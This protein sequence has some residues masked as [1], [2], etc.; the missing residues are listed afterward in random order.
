MLELHLKRS[1]NAMEDVD[2][3]LRK[4]QIPKGRLVHNVSLGDVHDEIGL[5]CRYVA[6]G[7]FSKQKNQIEQ[8]MCVSKMHNGYSTDI[9]LLFHAHHF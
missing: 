5:C 6:T 1:R 3:K 8:S 2:E 9:A 7:N 4:K